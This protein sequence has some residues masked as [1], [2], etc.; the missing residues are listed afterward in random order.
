MDENTSNRTPEGNTFIN[1]FVNAVYGILLGYGFCD[2]IGEIKKGA[3][4]GVGPIFSSLAV[5][6]TILVVCIYWWDWYKNIGR[7]AESNVREFALDI[8]ILISLEIL[9]FV[10]ENP[11]AFSF[12]FLVLSVL[13]LAWVAN[14]H[15]HLCRMSGYK[16]WSEYVNTNPEVA[17]YLLNR[18]AGIGLFGTCLL[19]TIILGSKLDQ[20][21]GLQSWIGNG[22]WCRRLEGNWLEF[23]LIVLV[24]ALNRWLFFKHRPGL[25][26]DA[27]QIKTAYKEEGLKRKLA[28]TPNHGLYS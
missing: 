20:N 13:S 17:R 10:Y 26:D 1:E 19:I 18:V 22:V 2:S 9:F 24:V 16:K 28:T 25:E 23:F 11:I 14:Y 7:R 8:A 6:F 27:V 5:A 3:P 15:L 12:V 21:S 4:E